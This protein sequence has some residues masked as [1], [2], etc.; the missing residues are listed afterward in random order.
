MRHPSAP[1]SASV[2]ERDESKTCTV[3]VAIHERAGPAILCLG[4]DRMAKARRVFVETA[5]L[6]YRVVLTRDR[7]REIVRFKHP[8]LAGHET[9]VRDC[10]REPD[11]IR[12]SA[13]DPDVHL[14]Y[15]QMQ[16]GYVCTVVGGD[17]PRSRF[18]ITAYFTRSLKKGSDLWTK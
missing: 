10:I 5:R 6:G 18:V 2:R 17:D 16:N 1:R 7:W 15:R 13:K 12:A 9:T 11:V 14:Y 4:A 3:V 8:A